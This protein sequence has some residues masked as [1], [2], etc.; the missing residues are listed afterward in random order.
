MTSRVGTVYAGAACS[1]VFFEGDE[2]S[3]RES[4]NDTHLFLSNLT[5][6]RGIRNYCAAIKFCF[7]L[8]VHSRRELF[9]LR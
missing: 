2:I 7:L 8:A 5:Q 1:N 4:L 6:T 9:I 3:E